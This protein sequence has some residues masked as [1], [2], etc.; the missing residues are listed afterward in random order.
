MQAA[1]TAKKPDISELSSQ[2]SGKKTHAQVAAQ[3]KT[4][5]KI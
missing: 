2:K 4:T 3:A 1:N 5:S